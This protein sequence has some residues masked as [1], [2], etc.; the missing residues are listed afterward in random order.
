MD[1]LA[2][3]TIP[4]WLPWAILFALVLVALPR[5]ESRWR[6]WGPAAVVLVGAS[7][8]TVD[9]L[10]VT[11]DELADAT[12]AAGAAVDGS[13]GGVTPDRLQIE[14]EDRL[15]RAVAIEQVDFNS[16]DPTAITY[17]FLVTRSAGDD[18]PATCAYVVEHR[19]DPATP[20][21]RLARVTSDNEACSTSSK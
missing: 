21:V 1:R 13:P 8:L 15:G 17:A 11:Q 19:L 14:I 18:S 5:P 7:G 2:P 9:H 4:L 6:A 20:G 12:A 16:S 10:W 3:V